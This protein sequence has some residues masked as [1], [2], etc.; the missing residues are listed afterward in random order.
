MRWPDQGVSALD[1]GDTPS[2]VAA[3]RL[4]G[5]EDHAAHGCREPLS[6]ELLL[7]LRGMIDGEEGRS[8]RLLAS[9]GTVYSEAAVQQVG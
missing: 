8:C 7:L 6:A 1:S 4:R 9:D 3:G 5:A 2:V